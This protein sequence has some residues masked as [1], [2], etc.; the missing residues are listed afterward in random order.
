[1]QNITSLS[2]LRAI[3]KGMKDNALFL[4]NHITSE[5]SLK[6]LTIFLVNEN[7]ISFSRQAKE[8][9][10]KIVSSS[11]YVE[12]NRKEDVGVKLAFFEKVVSINELKLSKKATI[13]QVSYDLF[14]EFMTP[15]RENI[16]SFEYTIDTSSENGK[17]GVIC[18]PYIANVPGADGILRDI[19]TTHTDTSIVVER[20]IHISKGELRARVMVEDE[21][22][23][24]KY[25]AAGFK[26]AEAKEFNKRSFE[27][28]IFE[29]T[30]SRSFVEVEVDGE[31]NKAI[32]KCLYNITLHKD[33][34]EV[35]KTHANGTRMEE[36]VREYETI[37]NDERRIET[38]EERYMIEVPIYKDGKVDNIS[39][40]EIPDMA[41]QVSPY[42]KD[43]VEVAR[44]F[45]SLNKYREARDD[46][47]REE[48]E[49]VTNAANEYAKE[50]AAKYNCIIK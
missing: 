31:D 34:Y 22:R 6:N 28:T 49:R 11:I 29:D 9:Y 33:C 30:Y 14:S 43:F 3:V 36:C 42:L 44:K 1:M 5:N 38:R 45:G 24:G 35:T 20:A 40:D 13:F 21:I 4:I 18:A 50:L 10:G 39:L 17:Y 16:I 15:W 7:D 23:S 32:N 19:P 37:S 27:Y 12:I 46:F 2:E 25:D 41:Y 26:V 8:E 47:D 48:T